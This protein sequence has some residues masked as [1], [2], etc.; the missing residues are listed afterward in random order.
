MVVVDRLVQHHMA[1]DSSRGG[2]GETR[3]HYPHA[4]PTPQKWQSHLFEP[5]S[6]SFGGSERAGRRVFQE[7]TTECFVWPPPPVW[8]A[9]TSTTTTTVHRT[10][11][12]W[13]PFVD[14]IF[15]PWILFHSWWKIQRCPDSIIVK[16]NVSNKCVCVYVCVR[17]PGFRSRVSKPW[18]LHV[19]LPFT[20]VH[21]WESLPVRGCV[22]VCCWWRAT[23]STTHRCVQVIQ[24]T[25][26]HQKLYW[27]A[28]CHTKASRKL[29]S[30]HLSRFSLT[31]FL[32]VSINCSSLLV[33][34]QID[35]RKHHST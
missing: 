19:S 25:S 30:F 28:R 27:L 18:Q 32:L 29:F 22:C 2:S 31:I 21:Q 5:A 20:G 4:L 12:L 15:H 1:S 33:W 26:L 8:V 35:F 9:Q 24:I 17:F 23:C 3:A 13:Q 11:C 14:G 10:P 34:P 6:S 16:N 7:E